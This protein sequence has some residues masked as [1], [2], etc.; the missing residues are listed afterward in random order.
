[1]IK[2]KKHTRKYFSHHFSHHYAELSAVL[3]IIKEKKMNRF[4]TTALGVILA[5]ILFFLF[6]TAAQAGPIRI[7][8]VP[9]YTEYGH[10]A[11]NG[12]CQTGDYRRVMRFV[13]NQLHRHGFEVINAAAHEQKIEEYNR[14]SQRSRTDSQLNAR[15]LAAKYG[16]DAVYLLWLTVNLSNDHNAAGSLVRAHAILEGEGYDAAGRD[17]GAGISKSWTL[18]RNNR[19]QALV[20]VEKEVSY[21][22]GRVLTAWQGRQCPAGTAVQA[23]AAAPMPRP[24]YQSSQGG[25]LQRNITRYSSWVEVRLDGAVNY[26]TAEIFGK[27]VN[28]VTGVTEAKRYGSV[29]VP[30]NPQASYVQ[31]RV[32]IVDT[33][34]FRLQANILKMVADVLQNRGNLVLKGVPYRYTAAEID[35]LRAIRPGMSSAAAI[36]FVVDRELARDRE[37]SG[38]YSVY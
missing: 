19:D 32:H 35:L 11:R 9:H 20:D 25:I 37:F 36:Q 18:T 3:K 12:G 38:R 10:D 2:N 21:E 4:S 26:T 17:L 27:I 28:S 34:P 30:G 7:A 8:V 31:W 23:V 6:T 24:Q 29:I 14:V 22:V 13:N 33:D 15:S 1:L 16:T 5:N